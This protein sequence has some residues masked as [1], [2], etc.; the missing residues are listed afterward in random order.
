MSLVIEKCSG[1]YLKKS[2]PPLTAGQ[3]IMLENEMVVMPS[4]VPDE[5][6][7]RGVKF[8]AWAIPAADGDYYALSEIFYPGETP[9]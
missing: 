6:E 3:V 8:R 7:F 9:S 5:E 1:G 4:D 2:G